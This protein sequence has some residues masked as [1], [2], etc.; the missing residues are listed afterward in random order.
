MT[1]EMG[2]V[3]E[4]NA[5]LHVIYL[6]ARCVFHSQPMTMCGVRERKREKIKRH[7]FHYRMVRS[8]FSVY[9]TNKFK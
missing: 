8:N 5:M 3:F 1:P 2:K 9:P 6:P 4:S 7:L